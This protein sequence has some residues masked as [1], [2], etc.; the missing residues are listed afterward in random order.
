MCKT[1]A[2]FFHKGVK[3]GLLAL[4]LREGEVAKD[5]RKLQGNL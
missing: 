2:C 1:F 5:M 4:G 3:H